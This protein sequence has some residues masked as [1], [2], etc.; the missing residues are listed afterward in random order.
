VNFS[1]IP[2]FEIFGRDKNESGYPETNKKLKKLINKL[3]VS[4]TNRPDKARFTEC[5]SLLQFSGYSCPLTKQVRIV[6]AD[7]YKYYGF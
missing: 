2:K 1:H 6:V 5:S 7:M 4:F 3:K